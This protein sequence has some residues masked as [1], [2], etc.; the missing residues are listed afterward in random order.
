LVNTEESC[1]ERV[2]EIREDLCELM[3]EYQVDDE[4]DNTESSAPTLAKSGLL[5]TI[6]A[7]VASRRAPTM[8]RL[9]SELDRYLEDE[10]VPISVENFQILDWW[11][12]A[13]TRYLTLRK[14][15]RD[16]FAIPV[17]TVAS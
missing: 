10:L 8:I 5:S 15:A 7:H 13:S 16:T 4:K 6:S 2:H 3:K 14:I 1:V 17:S 11:K 12:V 9:K